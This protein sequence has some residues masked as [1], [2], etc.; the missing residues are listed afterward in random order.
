MILQM[1]LK[2]ILILGHGSKATETEKT[3][4]KIVEMVRE[5]N[6]GKIIEHAFLQLSEK[7]L[8][9]GLGSLLE[10]GVDDIKVIP[11]FLFAGL[12]IQEDI[13]AEIEK[14]LE[15]KGDIKVEMADTLGADPRLAEIV[16]ERIAQIY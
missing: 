3:L 2:G 15:G 9:K 11:Y 14:F 4:E 7:T 16:S 13:P 1:P 12:H 6:P 8:E 10:K 5:A